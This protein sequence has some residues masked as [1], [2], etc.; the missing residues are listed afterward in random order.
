MKQIQAPLHEK[1]PNGG[2]VNEGIR[3]TR[4]WSLK[5]IPALTGREVARRHSYRTNLYMSILASASPAPQLLPNM[6]AAVRIIITMR[7]MR[8]II[9]ISI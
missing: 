8:S 4:I 7:N 2:D 3:A 1:I 9:I 6:L 5:F